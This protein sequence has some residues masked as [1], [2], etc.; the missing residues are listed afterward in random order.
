MEKIV[1]I[2]MIVF[3]LFSIIYITQK[4]NFEVYTSGAK[5]RYASEFSSTNQGPQIYT[6]L[7]FKSAT[8]E[9]E[10]FKNNLTSNLA[11]PIVML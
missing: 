11:A 7:A 10:L 3:L 5:Q 1:L 9:S 8:S 6:D 4:Q 2:G